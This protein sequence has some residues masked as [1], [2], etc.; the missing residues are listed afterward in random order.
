MPT[1]FVVL[2]VVLRRALLAG[3]AVSATIVL[4]ACAGDTSPSGYG[5]DRGPGMMSSGAPT[6]AATFAN[7]DVMFAR[8]MIPHHRQAI[9]MA[10]LAGTRA[11]DPEVKALAM[12]I[13]A[14][15]QPEIDTM[16]GWLSGALGMPMPG[17]SGG[18][19][20]PGSSGLSMPSTMPGM[21]DGGMQGSMSQADMTKLAALKGAV[22]DKQFL[23]MMIGHHRGAITMAKQEAVAGGNADA[24]A[25]AAKMVT[26]QQAQ[27]ATMQNILA[28]L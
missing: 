2:P 3:V 20:M 28:R 12:T 15:Q 19:P 13:K 16:T 7:A 5:M 9:E 25:L 21:G 27:I 1:H 18:M 10:D 17:V 22:F 6:V 4:S 8:M 23:T 26:D 11:A 24:K 14:A